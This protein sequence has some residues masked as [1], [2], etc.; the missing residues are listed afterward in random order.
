MK[1]T[2]VEA[3][4]DVNKNN[5]PTIVKDSILTRLNKVVDTELSVGDKFRVNGQ[6]IEVTS[7]TK[8]TLLRSSTGSEALGRFWELV[9][10]YESLLTSAPFIGSYEYVNELPA[11]F[12]KVSYIPYDLLKSLKKDYNLFNGEANIVKV[13][14]GKYYIK[15]QSIYSDN[16]VSL[17][18]VYSLIN[19]LKNNG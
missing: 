1:I 18:E 16:Q 14:G 13:N 3:V 8:L 19:Y 15:G 2:L 17:D 7:K 12:T 11:D 6:V 9:Q 5:C 4:R 10:D